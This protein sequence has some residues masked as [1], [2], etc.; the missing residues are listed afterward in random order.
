MDIEVTG[1]LWVIVTFT[2]VTSWSS[3][4]IG[5]SSIECVHQTEPLPSMVP[6]PLIVSPTSFVN[7]SHCR[8]PLPHAFAFVGAII[9]PSSCNIISHCLE[10]KIP[11]LKKI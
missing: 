9:V 3:L 8:R 10:S 11:N 4:S 2:S 5:S 6:F 7:S 1:G